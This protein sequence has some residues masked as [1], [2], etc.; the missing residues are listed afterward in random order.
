MAQTI[1]CDADCEAPADRLLT[2]IATG[3]VLAFCLEHFVVFSAQVAG[4]AFDEAAQ[5]AGGP[6]PDPE[7]GA[8]LAQVQEVPAPPA[9][10]S[11]GGV[12]PSPTAEDEGAPEPQAA[13]AGD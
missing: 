6:A 7:A 9:P 12:E 3:E 10:K 8:E 5:A 2:D 4:A 1:Y 11:A 13:A